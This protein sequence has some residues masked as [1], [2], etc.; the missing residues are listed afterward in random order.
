M[1][2]RWI[3]SFGAAASIL[4][5]AVSALAN[6]P[7]QGSGLIISEAEGV[8]VTRG[9]AKPPARRFPQPDKAPSV[10]SLDRDYRGLVFGKHRIIRDG[11]IEYREELLPI[12]QRDDE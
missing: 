9:K 12:R 11:R 1:V 6:A 8:T 5:G 10:V 4:S 7:A 2:L 3:A